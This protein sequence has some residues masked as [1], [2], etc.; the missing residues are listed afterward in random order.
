MARLAPRPRLI[1]GATPTI[2]A[3]FEADEWETLGQQCMREPY[4]GRP[5]FEA[6]AG[7]VGGVFAYQAGDGLG[8]RRNFTLKN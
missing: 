6:N 3:R 5:A 8:L 2:D 4:R 7:D 1:H